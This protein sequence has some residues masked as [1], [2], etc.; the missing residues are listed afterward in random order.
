M[1][2]HV[3][4]LVVSKEEAQCREK[5]NCNNGGRYHTNFGN[6]HLFYKIYIHLKNSIQCI[7]W[8]YFSL[9]ELSLNNEVKLWLS[10]LFRKDVNDLQ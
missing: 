2:L 3:Y 5:E 10:I 9:E 8:H 1:S 6:A 4:T 7:L